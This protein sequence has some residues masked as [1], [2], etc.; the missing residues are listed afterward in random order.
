MGRMTWRDCVCTGLVKFTFKFEVNG[1]SKAFTRDV[2][3]DAFLT[4]ETALAL[5]L[6]CA[7]HSSAG[8][9]SSTCSPSSAPL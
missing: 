2:S 9:G 3:L 1:T 7:Q 6:F 4:R 8:M 5:F